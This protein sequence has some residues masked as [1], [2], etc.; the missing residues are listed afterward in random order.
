M[1]QAMTQLLDALS[2]FDAAKTA[3]AELFTFF[4]PRMEELNAELGRALDQNMTAK[5]RLHL[6]KIVSRIT[7]ELDAVRELVDLLCEAASG[8][9]VRVLLT[10]LIE[11]AFKSPEVTPGDLVLHVHVVLST[12]DLDLMVNPRVCTA[13]LAHATSLVAYG[14]RKQPDDVSISVSAG[15]SPIIEITRKPAGGAGRPMSARQL[16]PPT[17][18]CLRAG[19]ELVGCTLTYSE[20][21]SPLTIGWGR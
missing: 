15:G 19:A 7:L 17:E 10:E 14:S 20:G 5:N 4:E 16:I 12:P 21:A 3:C 2:T 1:H 8:P 6:E 9:P 11:E 13:L 18:E